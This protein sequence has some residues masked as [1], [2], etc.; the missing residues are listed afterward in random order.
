MKS[1]EKMKNYEPRIVCNRIQCN[2]CEDII[3]SYHRHDFVMCKCGTVGT[4]GGSDYQITT[5]EVKDYTN[6][7]VYDDAP[8]EV[9]RRCFY[10]GGRGK[11]GRQPLT[12]VP[13]DKMSNEWVKACIVYNKERGLNKSFPSKMYR[14]ELKYR[15]EH[16]IIIHE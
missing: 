11:D 5:G 3:T 12:W 13:L 6:L 2:H 4:D 10:R 1:I 9:I 15:K 8:F 7:S 16:K 14:K